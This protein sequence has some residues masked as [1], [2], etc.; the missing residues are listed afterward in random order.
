[1]R[2]SGTRE[3]ADLTTAVRRSLPRHRQTT[4]AVDAGPCDVIATGQEL[5]AV[6]AGGDACAMTNTNTR[7]ASPEAIGH[8]LA[9][10]TSAPAPE[11][12]VRLERPEGLGAASTA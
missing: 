9:L 7:R 2:P 12:A 10:E 3:N 6:G 11:A 5:C 4:V 1:M 8:R